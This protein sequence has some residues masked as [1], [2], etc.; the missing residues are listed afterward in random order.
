MIGL[1]P[2]QNGS[3]GTLV[4]SSFVFSTCLA[5]LIEFF[6]MNQAC[7]GADFF[8]SS[9]AGRNLRLLVLFPVGILLCFEG[10]WS[11]AE[12]KYFQF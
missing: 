6:A 3:T 1:G 7:R 4:S 2:E 12:F 9:R 8:S 10:L 5:L 11:S